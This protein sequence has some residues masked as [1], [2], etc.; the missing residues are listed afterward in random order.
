MLEEFL[1]SGGADGCESVRL[2][3]AGG[4]T[5]ST[6]LARRA[7]ETFG[8]GVEFRNMYGPTEATIS[9]T[10][11]R[12]AADDDPLPI[13]R[14]VANTQVYLVDAR[15]Q[16]VPIGAPGELC[17][18]GVQVARGYLNRPELT[19]DRFAANPF[20]PGE[21]IY[22]TGDMARHRRDGAIEFLGRNDGQVKIR[23][24]RTELGE[25]EAAI[26]AQAG[27]RQAIAALRDDGDGRSRVVAYVVAADAAQPP[28]LRE[29]RA[30][31]AHR[32]P[33]NM[34]PSAV[35][36]IDT[37]PLTP[38]GKVDRGALPEP[39]WRT[40]AAFTAPRSVT[41]QRVAD[42][43]ARILRLDRVGVDDNFFELG[44]HSLLAVR[45]LAAVERQVG[46][47]VP[48]GVF[49]GTGATV[50]SM[51]AVIDATVPGTDRGGDVRRRDS[52]ALQFDGN[53][54]VLFFVHPSESSMLTLR[55]F[56]GPLGRNGRVLGLLPERIGQRFDR[57][58][59]VEDLAAPMLR[60]IRETQAHGPYYLAGFSFGGLLAYEVA[61]RLRSSGE[62]VAWLG[63]LDCPS[64]A[65]AGAGM[66]RRLSA[67]ER[68]ARQR[69]RGLLGA[70]RKTY[71][72][73]GRELRAGLL[74]LHLRRP[75][76][77]DDFDYRGAGHLVRRYVVRGNDAPM[78][79][80]PDR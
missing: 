43:W 14:P 10:W 47:A 78:N 72:V 32:L 70:T 29:L 37:V 5:V 63:L 68:L 19:A 53:A 13:G 6:G 45:L 39:D 38:S 31:L 66:R 60:T 40:S 71:E 28:A 55:H 18:G 26:A 24:V 36:L 3:T 11:W 76:L 27:V 67:R 17:I 20:I 9:S 79:S 57:R 21:R 42:V 77:S 52:V 4:E 62:E 16:P 7:M 25:I 69:K 44:G 59:S 15:L 74:R 41:E 23:G 73:A 50:S 35:A 12:C 33:Q 75:H 46:V 1:E 58:R 51:A 2:V 34:L 22:R 8:P 49:F 80:L 48:L 61:G 54:P 65:L 64:P 56:I 30:S